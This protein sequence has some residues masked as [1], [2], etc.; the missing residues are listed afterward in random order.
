MGKLSSGKSHFNMNSRI[1]LFYFIKISCRIAYLLV[2][3]GLKR[4]YNFMV[5]IRLSR[6]GAKKAPFYHVVVADSRKPRDG[7]FIERVG[8]YDP[9]PR[10]KATGTAL[11]LERIQYWTSKGATPSHRVSHVIK[12]F[13]PEKK[14]SVS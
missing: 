11:N 7:R 2:L 10:G 13:K 8:Y 1:G 3:T 5:V 4:K 12:T 9:S 14:E 6:G